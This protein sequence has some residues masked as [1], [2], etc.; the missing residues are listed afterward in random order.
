MHQPPNQP[1]SLCGFCLRNI[2]KRHKFINCSL[3]RS[4]IHIK[5]NNIELA[6]YNKMKRDKEVSMCRKCN[7]D[8]FPFADDLSREQETFNR[9]VLASE[10]IQMFFKGINDF[11][12][13]Q[14]NVDITDDDD[15]D[16]TP[17]IDCKYFDINSFKIFKDD[18]KKFSILHLNIASLEKHKNELTDLLVTLDFKFDVIGISETKIKEKVKPNFDIS[19]NGY[20]HYSTPTESNKGGVIIYIANKH[21]SIPRKGL[22]KTVYKS[23]VLESVFAEIIIPNKKNILL[24]CIYR[25]PSMEIKDFNENHLNP[26]MEKLSDKKHTFLLGDFNVDL[27]NT[28]SDEHTST[29]LDTF[30]SNL[31]VPHIIHPTRITPHSKTLI[32]NIFSNVPNFSQGKSGNLT[33]SISD[34]LAQFLI[35]PLDSGYVPRKTITYKRD[36]KN[37]DRDNFFLD[38]ISIE[39]ANVLQLE[40]EDPNLSF[41]S[42]Y[43]TINI[44]IDKYMPLRKMTQKEIKLQ[45]TPWITKDILQS[46]KIRENL[47]KKIIKAKD[48]DIKE[49]YHKNYK[50]IRNKILANSRQSKKSYFQKIFLQNSNNIKNTWKGIKAIINLNGSKKNQPSSLLINNKL[51]SE[52]KAVAESFNNY[53]SSIASELQSKIHYYGKDFSTFLKNSNPNNFFIKPTNIV[54]VINNINDLNTNKA[55]GPN[56]LPTDI[57][58]LIKLSIAQPLANII[59]LS[60]EKG[61]YID[62]LKISKVIPIFKDKGSDLDFINYRPISLLSNI[63]KII[64]KLMHERLFSFLE[65]YKCIYELQFGF[66]AGHSTTHALIDL[67]EDIRKAIDDN[68]FAVGVFIDL[69]KAF[70]TVDHNILL[71]KLDHYGIRGIAN[72]WF[73]SYLYNRNQFV[74][75]N[76]INSD[77]KPMKFGVPQ[78]SVLGPLLFLIYIN[79]L[80]SIIKYS[81]TRHFADDTNLLIKNKSL[82]QLKKHL[83]FDLRLLTSWLK[84]NKIS[85]NASKTEILIFRNPRKQINYD[86][87]IK[88]DG[89]RLY[90]S[91]SVKYLGILIDPHLNWSYHVKTLAPKLSRVIGMLAKIR[92]F[93]MD[94]IKNI[95]FGIFSSLLNYGAQVWGQH[96]NT[97]IKRI[98]KLQDKAIRIINFANFRE[99]TSNLYKKSEILKFK[100]NISLNNFLYVHNSLNRRLPT[101]LQDK[102]VYLRNSHLHTTRKSTYQCVKL[103]S[104]RTIDY[105]I[106]SITGQSARAWNYLQINNYQQLN[107]ISDDKILYLHSRS[108]CKKKLKQY[109]LDS[110]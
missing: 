1:D 58:H 52:P 41:K 96:H 71:K 88:L 79:D 4:K 97:H 7:N 109:F 10:D 75:I 46:I 50:E 86:L 110:Y 51:I 43:S 57:F 47:Y 90:P 17:I 33:I 98:I 18:N 42:Y 23:Y 63:N 55:M 108:I 104:S 54:E 37:F 70:D 67:T 5:C 102:F 20:K 13:Q 62:E 27:M 59:N 106:K 82:K 68:L 91:K 16:L 22:D 80:H 78:G 93:T 69:Q 36:T 26:L 64:E 85:L 40:K 84:A 38:L 56:S 77:L 49:N 72:T 9:E 65:K 44:L 81:R 39:W 107:C 66:R 95:Y 19:I 35:I 11:N 101:A 8:N 89:K 99:P 3:C 24:G 94:N 92:H 74:S 45:Y 61:I 60:F 14:N 30:S 34:H 28:D 48:K 100:D 6:T 53:F 83:N 105:G 2:N 29:Y 103:P 21:N 76:N 31:L 87:K 12:N 25:H 15:F 73:K 32:D